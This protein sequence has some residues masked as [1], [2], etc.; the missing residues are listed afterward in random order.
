MPVNPFTAR[1]D[2]CILRLERMTSHCVPVSR[3]LMSAPVC[4]ELVRQCLCPVRLQGSKHAQSEALLP[5]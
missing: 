2:L 4:G 5:G 1:H 3:L